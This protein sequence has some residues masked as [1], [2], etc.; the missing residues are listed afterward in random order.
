MFISDITISANTDGKT[1]TTK[2]EYSPFLSGRLLGF[3]YLPTTGSAYSSGNS[4][5]ANKI[6]LTRRSTGATQDDVLIKKFP[7]Y[8]SR[9]HYTVS[10]ECRGTTGAPLTTDYRTPWVTLIDEQL[11]VVVQPATAATAKNATIKL[12]IDGPPTLAYTGT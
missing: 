7:V 4:V 5:G 1:G 6:L 9:K 12:L 8:P 3:T 2:Y 10:Q 11:R